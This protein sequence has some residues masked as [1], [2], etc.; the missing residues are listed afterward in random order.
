MS[1]AEHVSIAYEPIIDAQNPPIAA[2]SVLLAEA[3]TGSIRVSCF[4]GNPYV[5][6]QD[7]IVTQDGGKIKRMWIRPVAVIDVSYAAVR[8]IEGYLSQRLFSNN[9]EL[10]SVLSNN[11]NLQ[12]SIKAVLEELG[13]ERE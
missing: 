5:Q 3:L 13:T 7:E 4:S 11:P 9:E 10:K 12:A 6:H 2:D 1:E 8:Y